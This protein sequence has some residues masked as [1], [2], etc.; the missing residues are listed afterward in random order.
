MAIEWFGAP[1]THSMC[2]RRERGTALD[3]HDELTGIVYGADCIFATGN[4]GEKL[5][6]V[7]L[8]VQRCVGII[9][10]DLVAASVVVES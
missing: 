8:S 9:R 10:H 5:G 7:G 3:S 6:Y 4:G 2:T 1:A